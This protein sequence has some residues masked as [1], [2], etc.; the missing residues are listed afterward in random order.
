[1]NQPQ[2][3]QLFNNTRC[4]ITYSTAATTSMSSLSPIKANQ[5][6]VTTA[7]GKKPNPQSVSSTDCHTCKSQ[8]RRCDRQRPQCATCTS[9]VEKCGGFETPLQWDRGSKSSSTQSKHGRDVERT[10]TRSKRSSNLAGAT[11]SEADP[12]TFAHPAPP[13]SVDAPAS[14]RKFTFVDSRKPKRRKRFDSRV[15]NGKGTSRE[16]HEEVNPERQDSHPSIPIV[17]KD[18]ILSEIEGALYLHS[19]L[20]VIYVLNTNVDVSN[21][22]E[23]VVED[24]PVTQHSFPELLPSTMW[25]IDSQMEAFLNANSFQDLDPFGGAIQDNLSLLSPG[26]GAT[27]NDGAD[28]LSN[29]SWLFKMTFNGGTTPNDQLNIAMPDFS[30]SIP[31]PMSR[32]AIRST[33][34]I[35]ADDLLERCKISGAITIRYTNSKYR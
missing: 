18:S 35:N 2:R 29:D 25:P 14:L 31:A 5:Q 21:G 16:T 10:T 20:Q 22:G 23:Y 15:G 33:F 32:E 3:Q 7:S 19:Q 9:H 30:N 1:M 28:A 11:N 24:P 34:Q 6:R 26:R 13:A 8:G 17:S 12:V 27:G 4:R